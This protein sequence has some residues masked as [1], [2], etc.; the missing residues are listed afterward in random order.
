M[1]DLLKEGC[2]RIE[3]RRLLSWLALRFRGCMVSLAPAARHLV[4]GEGLKGCHQFMVLNARLERQE[5]FVQEIKKIGVGSVAFHGCRAARVFNILTDALRVPSKLPYFKID[6]GISLSNDPDYSTEYAQG[7]KPFRA[8]KNS[9]FWGTP[10]TSWATMFGIEV[11]KP[12][13]AFKHSES[14]I[15]DESLVM[16]RYVFLVPTSDRLGRSYSP[17]KLKI[18]QIAMKKAFKTLDE[19]T[20]S[21]RHIGRNVGPTEKSAAKLTKLQ[22]VKCRPA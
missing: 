10:G 8:W 16:V 11:A 21:P 20:L 13:V 9:Q 15:N 17:P 22:D 1:S 2:F 19:D 7:D 12:C 18:D 6:S 5:K 14:S 3:R 4:R